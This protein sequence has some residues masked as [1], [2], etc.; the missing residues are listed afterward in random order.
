MHVITVFCNYLFSF[1][2]KKLEVQAEVEVSD[3]TNMFW[4]ALSQESHKIFNWS[5]HP[6]GRI[7]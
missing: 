2:G 5:T 6:V 7:F 1:R 4:L 3:N